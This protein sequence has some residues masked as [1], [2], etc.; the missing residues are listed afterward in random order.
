MGFDKIFEK[1]EKQI[2]ASLSDRLVITTELDEKTLTLRTIS[3]WDG[4]VV[5]DHDFDLSPIVTL[6][7]KRLKKK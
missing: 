5:S 3:S 6:I 2:L 1:V 7:E 4:V